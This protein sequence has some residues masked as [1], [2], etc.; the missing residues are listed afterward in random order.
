MIMDVCQKDIYIYIERERERRRERQVLVEA[1][2]DSSEG[3][4]TMLRMSREIYQGNDQKS[5]TS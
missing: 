2:N 4:C 5:L 3:K 1:E